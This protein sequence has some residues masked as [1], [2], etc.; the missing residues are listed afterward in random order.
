MAILG[1]APGRQ[2]DAGVV[3][4]DVQ[5]DR[6]ALLVGIGEGADGLEGGQI[7][8]AVLREMISRRMAS[9][10]SGHHRLSP[11]ASGRPATGGEG[12]TETNCRTST[13]AFLLV[14]SCLISRAAASP[15]ATS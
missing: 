15:L 7:E 6:V 13:L 5:A 14:A 11:A 12:K 4:E 3:A 1:L 8:P 10:D 9:A 2:H